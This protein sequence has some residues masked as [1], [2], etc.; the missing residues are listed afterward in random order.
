ML[1][2]FLVSKSPHPSVSANARFYM[3]LA[4]LHARLRLGES[5]GKL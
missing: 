4:G 1:S 2:N 5:F 3:Y